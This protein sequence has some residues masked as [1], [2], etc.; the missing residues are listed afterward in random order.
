MKLAI[1]AL[2]LL[3]STARADVSSAD[4]PP[5]LDARGHELWT[6]YTI[7]T[8]PN[9]YYLRGDFD[10][11][12]KADYVVGVKKAG[13]KDD[14]FVVLRAKGKPVWIDASAIPTD[15]FYVVDRSE[16]IGVGASGGKPPKLKGDAIMFFKSES[17][18]ALV[19][20]TGK[21]FAVYWQG[22]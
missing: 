2:L 6:D 3:A 16:K 8:T 1:G 18:S 22:D 13:D 19:Y 21:K 4:L 15:G 10:G 20:W 14:S 9:P 11:D 5:D 12:H 17:S 7:D